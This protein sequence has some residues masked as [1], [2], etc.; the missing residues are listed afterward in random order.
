VTILFNLEH[1]FWDEIPD[2]WLSIIEAFAVLLALMYTV[3]AGLGKRYSWFFA[4]F[5]SLFLGFICL[6]SNYVMDSVLHLFYMLAAVWGWKE[7]SKLSFTL[8]SFRK[9][10]FFQ[11]FI[12]SIL[13]LSIGVLMG[14]WVQ[15]N[16]PLADLPIWDS[17]TTVL[18]IAGTVLIVYRFREAWLWFIFVDSVGVWMYARKALFGVALLYFVYT[19]LAGFAFYKWNNRCLKLP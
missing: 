1:Y 2:F 19:L 17:C 9:M 10:P 6:K 11:F 14:L 12:I 5:S 18:S 15:E 16:V 8:N 4:F 3:F 13:T 7:W